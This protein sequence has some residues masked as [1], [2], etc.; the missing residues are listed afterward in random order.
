MRE[1]GVASVR[2][3]RSSYGKGLPSEADKTGKCIYHLNKEQEVETRRERGLSLRPLK[4]EDLRREYLGAAK[5]DQG[6]FRVLA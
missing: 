2:P 3:G 1:D 5:E 6:S 4:R